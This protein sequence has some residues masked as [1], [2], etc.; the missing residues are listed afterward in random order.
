MKKATYLMTI[1]FAVAMM[2]TSC[3]K[4]DPI[5]PDTL[6]EQY[7][8]WS[9][10]SWV[11]TDDKDAS[12]Q[13]VEDTYPRLE[14][15]IIGDIVQITQPYNS[16]A[17]HHY[18]GEFTEIIITGNVISFKDDTFKVVTGT[19]S[20]NGNQITFTTKGLMTTEHE[21]ILQ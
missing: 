10:L 12:W 16:E 8:E 11:S 7:P 4:E 3:E 14:I 21:Y 13:P 18:F 20:V 15:S 19:F 9:N 1:L 17:G 6:E 2:S 5:V